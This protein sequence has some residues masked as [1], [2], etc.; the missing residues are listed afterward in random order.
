MRASE[1]MSSCVL[2]AHIHSV[3]SSITPSYA[4]I[5]HHTT[6]ITAPSHNT[7]TYHIHYIHY[8][9][10]CLFTNSVQIVI[11]L[12]LTISCFLNNILLPHT[13]LLLLSLAFIHTRCKT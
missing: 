6:H 10:K 2:L 4:L 1:C 12:T 7:L 9:H 8:I 13:L 5:T 11:S 3:H